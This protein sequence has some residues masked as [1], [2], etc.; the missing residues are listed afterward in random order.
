MVSL[1]LDSGADVNAGTGAAPIHAAVEQQHLAVVKV[2]LQAGADPC[3]ALEGGYTVLH[4]AAR[5]GDLAIMQQLLTALNEGQG[6]GGVDVVACGRTPLHEA[7]EYDQHLCLEALVAAGADV[8]K[9][10]GPGAG[11][12]LAGLSPMH[13]AVFMCQK[14]A[15]PLLATP[16]NLRA[17]WGGDTPL[18]LALRLECSGMVL[19]LLAA[20]APACLV[21]DN[22]ASAMH[23]AGA[24]SNPTLQALL[25]AIIRNE[26]KQGQLLKQ[27]GREAL[28]PQT[29][30]EEGE[31]RGPDALL[32]E[33][34]S[35]M[36]LLLRNAGMSEWRKQGVA[37]FKA[38][39]EVLG[40]PAAC[41]LLQLVLCECTNSAVE[42]PC[43]GQL[44]EVLRAVHTEWLS[45]LEPLTQQRRRLTTRLH[46]L[47]TLPLQ[48]QADEA[49]GKREDGTAMVTAAGAVLGGQS[50]GGWQQAHSDWQTLWSQAESAAAAGQ[51]QVVV[52]RLEVLT[53]LQPAPATPLLYTLATGAGSDPA[54]AVAGL[55][56]ALVNAWCAVQQQAATRARVEA[57]EGV[58]GAVQAWATQQ[59]RA[60]AKPNRC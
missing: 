29:Q 44:L 22:G 9:P 3:A 37:C 49:G 33:A 21:N 19:A 46:Y 54:Q 7:L 12:H 53:A 48:Q 31:E 59:V 15:V 55:C 38:V 58:V 25:P 14:D 42:V 41:S 11:G 43:S 36:Y 10:Y 23:L 20:G 6:R 18:H 24:S 5:G 45:A 1:L 28:P 57:A 32:A 8:S 4:L 13:K 30:Q 26:C 16:S 52:Q 34:A 60:G 39:L 56:E 35:S 17:T 51:W 27:P 47:V 2:L 40:A 50:S